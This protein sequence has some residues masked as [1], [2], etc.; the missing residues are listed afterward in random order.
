MTTITAPTI[1]APTDVPTR[2]LPVELVDGPGGGLYLLP[3]APLTPDD[4]EAL[5]VLLAA[6]AAA[7]RRRNESL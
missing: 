6:R 3:F 4:C 2:P 1:T 7:V 5:S